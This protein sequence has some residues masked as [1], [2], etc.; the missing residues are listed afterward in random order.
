MLALPRCAAYRPPGP[1]LDAGAIPIAGARGANTLG[2]ERDLPRRS[3]RLFTAGGALAGGAFE[4][5][6]SAKPRLGGGGIGGPDAINILVSS[7]TRM[8]RGRP[9]KVFT[10]A[11]HVGSDVCVPTL[12][13]V[14]LSRE[15]RFFA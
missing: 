3:K 5:L 4:K 6:P 10:M 7:T 11:R 1:H 13:R 8:G 2:G 9:G 15:A 14:D 12:L